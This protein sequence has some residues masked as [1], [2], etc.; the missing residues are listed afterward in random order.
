MNCLHG[1]RTRDEI[2]APTHRPNAAAINGVLSC[3]AFTRNPLTPAAVVHCTPSTHHTLSEYSPQLHPALTQATAAQQAG[4]I[5][6]TAALTGLCRQRRVRKQHCNADMTPTHT[7]NTYAHAS[8]L[9][10]WLQ[11]IPA[12]LNSPPADGGAGHLLHEARHHAHKQRTRATHCYHLR[13]CT[14]KCKHNRIHSR[15]GTRG[16]GGHLTTCAFVRTR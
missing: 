15:I 6:H 16:T 11:R 5:M 13:T 8:S 2:C 12:A 10:V 4:R 14:C 3:R 7:P 9:C 1:S